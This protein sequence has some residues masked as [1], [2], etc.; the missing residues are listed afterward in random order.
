M[1]QPADNETQAGAPGS[2]IVFDLR[3]LTRFQDERPS[4]QVLSDIGTARI[5]LFAFRA[6]QQLKEHKTSSQILV[7]ALRGRITFTAAGS[8]VR[9]QAGTLIQLEAN[10]P[11]SVTAHTDAVMLLTMTPSPAHQSQEPE[12]FRDSRPLVA[13][14][15]ETE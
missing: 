9:L 5:V 13:R 7:Q 14:T 3:T 15:S 12:I 1:N 4:V 10:I 6:G 2:L 8:S 11:H